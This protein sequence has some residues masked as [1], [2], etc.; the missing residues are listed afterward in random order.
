MKTNLFF[1]NDLN[2]S[3]TP[4]HLDF[5]QKKLQKNGFVR[6]FLGCFRLSF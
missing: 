3:F 1:S 2:L 4:P 5:L 6:L